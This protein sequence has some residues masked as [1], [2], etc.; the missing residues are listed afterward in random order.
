M[1]EHFE[2]MLDRINEGQPAYRQIKQLI[3]RTEPFL[4]NSTGKIVRAE[5]VH[6]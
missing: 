1:S 5:A 6:S 3:I 2:K 4:R